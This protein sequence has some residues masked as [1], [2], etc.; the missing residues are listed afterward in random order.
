M[1]ERITE[2]IVRNH[3]KNDEC[4]KKVLFEEQKTKIPRVA[5]L[6]KQASKS[7]KGSGKPEFI[8]TT[9][10]KPELVIVIECKADRLKHESTEHNKPKEY[11]VDGAL[12]YS[13]YLKQEYDVLSIAISGE[14]KDNVKISH[15]IQLKGESNAKPIFGDK[16]LAIENY[17]SYNDIDNRKTDQQKQD[18]LRYSKV[19]NEELHAI[20]VK[21]SQRSLLISGIL[22]ALENKAFAKSYKEIDASQ[23]LADDLVETIKKELGKA[24]KQKW[25]IYPLHIVLSKHTQI[26]HKTKEY[27]VI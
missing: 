3:F 7:G 8:L 24:L 4:Y 21:E 6:L 2:D 10:V 5:K 26:Y 11:A 13:D 17:L 19:L 12:L 18:L 9:G 22:I 25:N 1:N 27:Y 15:F 20:K 14:E 23:Q 16:L